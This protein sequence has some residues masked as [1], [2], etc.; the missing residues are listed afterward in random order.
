MHGY[1]RFRAT[2][3]KLETYRLC[4]MHVAI[5]VDRGSVLDTCEACFLASQFENAIHGKHN[6]KTKSSDAPCCSRASCCTHDA[7]LY[8]AKGQLRKQGK[9]I[10]A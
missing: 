5:R 8:M 2:R 1:R 10:G 7:D 6:H 9:V 3:C 4:V